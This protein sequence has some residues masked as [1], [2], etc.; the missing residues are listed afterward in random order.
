MRFAIICLLILSAQ[1]FATNSIKQ[2]S[3][4][5]FTADMRHQAGFFDFYY[6]IETDKVFLKID[7]FD[8][9]FL[10]Q[11]SMPI[12]LFY[13]KAVCHKVLARMILV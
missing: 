3:V 5:D 2:T 1:V 8:Q 12:S 7:K 13:F 9:P 4:V 11:S 10:F 6:Q